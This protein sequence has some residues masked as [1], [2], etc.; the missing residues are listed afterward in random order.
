MY[1][2]CELLQGISVSVQLDGLC[3]RFLSWEGEKQ[4][5]NSWPLTLSAKVFK[6]PQH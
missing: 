5:L 4:I 1:L 3:G 6:C 2:D